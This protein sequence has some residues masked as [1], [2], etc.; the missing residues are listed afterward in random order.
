MRRLIFFVFLSSISVFSYSV[1]SKLDLSGQG[2][3][4][5]FFI[6]V[7][8]AKL[9]KEDGEVLYSKPLKLELKYLRDFKGIDIAIQSAKELREMGVSEDEIKVWRPRMEEIFPNVQKGDLITAI[10]NP[11]S[12]ITFYLN[13]ERKVGEI[14][15]IDFSKQFLDIWL[16]EKSS[17][18]ELR[19]KLL[20]SINE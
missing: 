8:E 5:W 17:A 13:K 12:G 11:N 14:P 20:G 10:F 9:W 19:K 16:G 15:N 1:E 7:Y 6:D 2:V 3:Y 4:S 18:Q